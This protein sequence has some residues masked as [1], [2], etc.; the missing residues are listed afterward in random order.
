M[1]CAPLST[2]SPTTTSQ[3]LICFWPDVVAD[4]R[5]LS[6]S[7][8]DAALEGIATATL[9]GQSLPHERSDERWRWLLVTSAD[10]TAHLLVWRDVNEDRTEL[11]A[12]LPAGDLVARAWQPA[13]E[14]DDVE[15]GP[16]QP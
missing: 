1:T 9:V 8:L 3:E 13:P 10:L 15:E 11:V 4:L 6:S 5:A 14:P 2:L 16:G 12:V 7:G